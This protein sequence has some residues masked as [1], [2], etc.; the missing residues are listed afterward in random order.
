MTLSTGLLMGMSGEDKKAMAKNRC[1]AANLSHISVMRARCQESR[2][3]VF[4]FIAV[5]PRDQS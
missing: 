4:F 2:V 1:S 5:K 3:F